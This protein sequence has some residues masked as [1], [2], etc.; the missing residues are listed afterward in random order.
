MLGM[1]S[2]QNFET[3]IGQSV[4]D[5][6][7]TRW[8]CKCYRIESFIIHSN[9]CSNCGLAYEQNVD[10]KRVK[11]VF[12]CWKKQLHVSQNI[13]RKLWIAEMASDVNAVVIISIVFEYKRHYNAVRVKRIYDMYTSC[14]LNI[15]TFIGCLYSVENIED[16]VGQRCICVHSTRE[17]SRSVKELWEMDE[18]DFENMVQ[19]LPR[20][21]MQETLALF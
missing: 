5:L 17:T 20:E 13:L 8:C 12:R 7:K 6:C 10:I 16:L 4:F 14:S 15:T 3:A 1:T 2:Y 19:W 21:M 9:V 11:H 18:H